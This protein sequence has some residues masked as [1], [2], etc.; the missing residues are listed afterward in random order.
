MARLTNAQL[1]KLVE[2][3]QGENAVLRDERDAAEAQAE[4]EST[5][6]R[7][8]EEAAAA[9]AS[10]P[11]APREKRKPRGRGWTVL[12]TA[13][14]VIGALLAPVAVAANWAKLQLSDTNSFVD[15]FAPLAQDPGVQ[16][17]ITTEVVTA[18]DNQIHID[19]ITSDVFDSIAGL[20]LGPVATQTLG[21]FKGVAANGIRTLMTNAVGAFV[22]SDAFAAIWRQALTTSH[23]QLVSAMN[24]D[25]NSALSI[26][27]TGEVGIQ[28]GPIIAQV[29]TLLVGQGITFAENIPDINQT[30][31]VA[32]S[33]SVVKAQLGYRL[34]I[35]IGAWLPW[36]ALLFLVAGVVV[37]SRRTIAMLWAAIALA[38]AMG[39]IIVGVPI[40]ELIFV[41]SVS[42]QYLPSTV[43]GTLYE[44]I[45]AL[46]QS[47]A[48]AVAVLAITV[49]IVGFLTGPFRVSRAA[50]SLVGSGASKVRTAVAKRG[51]TT[52][53]A[54]ILL[55][56]YRYISRALLALIGAAIVI[57]TR[58]LTPSLI[59]WTAVC[60]V[61]A[62]II[63]ELVQR[64]ADEIAQTEAER[65]V[66]DQAADDSPAGDGTT[67]DGLVESGLA[68]PAAGNAAPAGDA[69]LPAPAVPESAATRSAT[70]LLDRPGP[71]AKTEAELSDADTVEIAPNVTAVIPPDAEPGSGERP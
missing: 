54:G 68:V 13:L 24:G 1:E 9:A 66:F 65:A 52:G 36:I 64:P 22:R 44:S 51:V 70:A 42:P 16:D 41:G 71:G 20:G 59:I 30:I 67:A 63:L 62:L 69:R 5:A 31:V 3:L 49:A 55:Y 28:L 2:Q 25:P 33:D 39:L 26:S 10:S 14:I 11:R 7:L 43:A 21:A 38:L 50:R 57:F 23:Q 56:R 8:A 18:I 58:P 19:K 35:A 6:R 60:I 17:Y 45:L 29:K 47:T 34:A 37:A 61:I 46:A 40:G 4:A 15:T 27:G 48:V 12:A 53:R 32:Q